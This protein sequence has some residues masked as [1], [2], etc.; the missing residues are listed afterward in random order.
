MQPTN[1]VSTCSNQFPSNL[2]NQFGMHSE[3]CDRLHIQHILSWSIID[4]LDLTSNGLDSVDKDGEWTGWIMTDGVEL[5]VKDEPRSRRV[6]LVLVLEYIPGSGT[7][8]QLSDDGMIVGADEEIEQGVTVS[9]FGL[10]IS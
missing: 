5:V 7:R 3:S 10:P 1:A 6:L 4:S 2:L 9:I 8:R